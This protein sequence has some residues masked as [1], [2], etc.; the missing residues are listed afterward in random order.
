MAGRRA[1][2][3]VLSP[4]GGA[5][6][7]SVMLSLLS[8]TAF[9]LQG[10]LYTVTGGERWC[11]GW[12]RGSVIELDGPRPYLDFFAVQ[13][14]DAWLPPHCLQVF[15]HFS[16]SGLAVLRPA[17]PPPARVPIF[18]SDLLRCRFTRV[19]AR[20]ALRAA[21]DHVGPEVT[22]AVFRAIFFQ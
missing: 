14:G 17:K 3:G 8:L 22:C 6:V 10:A 1:R 13:S 7:C 12:G 2:G 19:T 9:A 4:C 15:T 21:P 5:A 18:L 20:S 16:E 11:I